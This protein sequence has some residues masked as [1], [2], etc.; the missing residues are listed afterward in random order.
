MRRAWVAA[1]GVFVFAAMSVAA[2]AQQAPSLEQ[3]A[4]PIAHEFPPAP[5]ANE[6]AA[7]RQAR[8]QSWH[9][10]NPNIEVEIAA[11][12][13]ASSAQSAA[14][15]AQLDA[16]RAALA[17]D[18][19]AAI[20]R[21][22]ERLTPAQ[23]QDTL[24][25]FSNAFALWQAGQFDAAEVLFVRGLDLDPANA[26][27]NYYL[28]DILKRKNDNDRAGDHMR[29]AVAFGP[30]SQ[31]AALAEVALRTLPAASTEP[32]AIRAAPPAIFDATNRPTALWDCASCPEMA[33]IP[34]GSVTIGSPDFERGRDS[35]EGPQQRV[36]IAR[37]FSVG[38]FE[39]TFEEWSACTR[40]GGCQGNSAPGDGGW[41]RGRRP[42]INV[43]WN[44]AQE[45]VRWLS[46]RT[47]HEYRLLTEAEWEYVAR[48]GTTSAY[49]WGDAAD[50]E[51]ANYGAEGGN[52]GRAFGSDVWRNT[53][54]VGAFP[55]NPFGLFET[56]GNVWEWVQDCFSPAYLTIIRNASAHSPASCRNYVGRGGFWGVPSVWL[57]IADRRADPADARYDG[58]GFRVARELP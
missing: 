57:R 42:V 39:V 45:Y 28:G 47:G 35:D 11:F 22:S 17:A 8:W 52:V 54:P 33:V 16:L 9:D 38:R 48:A 14:Y 7:Q 1:L 44:D 5:P 4:P 25:I 23:R 21:Q 34:A 20:R 29:R 26:P 13:Q 49:W 19:Y 53:A 36:T 32:E 2:S 46:Q 40:G 31:Q 55:A 18:P 37:P 43:S 58:L 50:H 27:A 41:G 12:V 10:A 24:G 51:H 6:T 15:R 3:G 56:S 30:N